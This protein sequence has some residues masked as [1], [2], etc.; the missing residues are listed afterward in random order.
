METFQTEDRLAPQT[1]PGLRSA[2]AH[3]S[4]EDLWKL[5]AINAESTSL[6][7][8]LTDTSLSDAEQREIVLR[9]DQVNAHARAITQSATEEHEHLAQEWHAEALE[10]GAQKGRERIAELTP[11][12]LTELRA[13]ARAEFR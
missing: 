3:L 8:R 11:Q 2:A 13:A 10:A 4:H 12:S 7:T 1:L 9:L 5:R 6:L